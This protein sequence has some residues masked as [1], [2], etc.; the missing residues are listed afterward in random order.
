MVKPIPIG[1]EFGIENES[2]RHGEGKECFERTID[3]DLYPV[4]EK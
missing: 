1:G 2:F 4:R 3:P